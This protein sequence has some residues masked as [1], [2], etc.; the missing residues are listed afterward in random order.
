V[1]KGCN[2]TIY[3][4]VLRNNYGMDEQDCRRTKKRESQKR[5]SQKKKNDVDAVDDE[6]AGAS[7]Q[8]NV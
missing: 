2:G 5:K 3:V 6:E 7:K 8:A 4:S 1:K